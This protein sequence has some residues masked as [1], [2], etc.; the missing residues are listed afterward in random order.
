MIDALLLC[1]TAF[2]LG[3]AVAWALGG[4]TR[5]RL[6]AI[7][8]RADE[9]VR[10]ADDKLELVAETRSK[11]TNE[12][13]AL[14]AEA[15]DASSR[16]FLS[17]ATATFEKFQERAHGD[18]AARE[19]AVHTL[20]QPIRESLAHVDGKIGELEKTRQH[21]Y[22]ALHEQLR[23]LVETHLP[24]KRVVEMAG[25]LEQCDFLEQPTGETDEDRRLRPD[26][27]VKLP[28][29]RHVVVDAKVP[30]SA[31]VDAHEAADDAARAAHFARHAQI[32]RQHM[33]ALGR[34]AYWE[35][36]DPAP[37]FVIM[38][39]P[40]EPFWSAAVQ[41]D[42][43]LMEFGVNE[44]VL[45]ATP[46]NLIGM[47]RAIAYGW[48][49]E[50][51]AVNAR[52]VA[53]LGKQLYERIASLAGH[54]SDVGQKLGKAVEGYNK[55]VGALETRVLVT[56]RKFE[57]LKAAPEGAEIESPEPVDAVPRGL[58]AAELVV[59]EPPAPRSDRVYGGARSAHRL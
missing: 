22:S 41:V 31:Y 47:L 39:L 37:E 18:L 50:A 52:E 4:R 3:F 9:Q 6:A 36:F 57:T 54:W 45:V 26:L 43:G 51:L 13:K 19:Q 58:Q 23:G 32:V 24:L 21:A 11:L 56:A 35:T 44:G 29:G 8:A 10:A 27:V 28:G 33:T 40:A 25:M 14:S 46:M 1:L 16:S 38:F 53:D 48:K 59:V 2:A 55:S 30:F 7:T 5:E 42:S 34:K 12:L 17:L 20:V 15:L 49:Q